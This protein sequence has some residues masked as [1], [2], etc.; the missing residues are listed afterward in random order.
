MRAKLGVSEALREAVTSF[1]GTHDIPLEVV[2]G[3]DCNVRVVEAAEGE[4]STSS[5]LHAGGWITCNTARGMAAELNI[6]S[7]S[8]GQ[9][10]DHLN[11]KIRA[12]E[13]GCFD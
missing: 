12:C 9:L 2:S 4:K 7:R 5:V 11:I 10:L 1:V 13:L 6:G 3:D 8:L